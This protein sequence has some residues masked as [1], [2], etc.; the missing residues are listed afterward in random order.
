M[1]AGALTYV[2]HPTNPTH[3][4]DPTSQNQREIVTFLSV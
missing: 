4:A 1:A 3:T 2:T